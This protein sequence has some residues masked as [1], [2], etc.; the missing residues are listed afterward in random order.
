MDKSELKFTSTYELYQ[1]I[2]PA[3]NTK[4]AEF[5]REKID[6]EA[7]DIW[8]YCLKNKWQYRKDLR[9][10]E[11]VADILNID[12]INLEIYLKKKLMK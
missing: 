7:I 5:R 3:L 6:V 2:L 1:R 8:N 4:V 9:I 10:Y 12:I 11:L